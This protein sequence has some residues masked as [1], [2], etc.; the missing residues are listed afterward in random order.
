MSLVDDLAAAFDLA[1]RAREAH[2]Y[3]VFSDEEKAVP[4]WSCSA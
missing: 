1:S 4:T 3:P 2:P